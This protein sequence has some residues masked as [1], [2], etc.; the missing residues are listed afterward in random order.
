MA[1]AFVI[2]LARGILVV[3]E[4]G[5]IIDTMLNSLS[6]IVG[7]V[8]PI[9]SAQLMF[10]VQT[11]LNLFVPSGSGQAALTMPIMAPLADL[12]VSVEDA[13]LEHTG[14]AVA[15]DDVTIVAM[16]RQ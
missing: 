13:L 6:S 12:V 14:D 16:R 9:V 15:F 8:H 7:Q 4:D 10:A 3:A 1:T 5:R 11:V 2:A